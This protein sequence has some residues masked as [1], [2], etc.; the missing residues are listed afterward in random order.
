MKKH[1]RY[2]KIIVRFLNVLAKQNDTEDQVTFIVNSKRDFSYTKNVKNS[3]K[4]ETSKMKMIIVFIFIVFFFFK[5]IR[6]LLRIIFIPK[7][8]GKYLLEKMSKSKINIAINDVDENSSFSK[9]RKKKIRKNIIPFLISLI[10]Y[11]YT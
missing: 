6:G 9:K 10:N 7:G 8:Y 3:E 11:L 2:A 4:L 1:Y 5:L